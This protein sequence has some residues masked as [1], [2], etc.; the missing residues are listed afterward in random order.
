MAVRISGGRGPA[1]TGSAAQR[2]QAERHAQHAEQGD[3]QQGLAELRPLPAL[4]HEGP[5]TFEE[6]GHRVQAGDGVSQPD[7]WERGTYDDVR[8][9]K[10]KNSRKVEF[11]A[12]GLPVFRA[13][14]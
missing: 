6:I 11:T 14:A 13:M 5:Q 8:K 12:A 3:G 2:G 4:A 10:G 9:R 1:S 7:S